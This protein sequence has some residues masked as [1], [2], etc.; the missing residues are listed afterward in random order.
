MK[1]LKQQKLPE[2]WQWKK[3]GE[4]AEVSSGNGAPQDESYFDNGGSPFVRTYDVGVFGRTSDLNESR[5]RINNQAVKDHGMQLFPARTLLIPKSGASTFLNNRALLGFP[6][7]VSSH[8]ATVIAKE[9]VL[10]EFL[11]Y[12]SLTVDAKRLTHDVSYPSLRLSEIENAEVPLPS[13]GTQ[14]KIISILQKAESMKQSRS[15]STKLTQ[16]LLQSV[17]LE[18]FGD[19][20]KNSMG[21]KISSIG[22]II[23]N[24][25]YGTSKK[26]NE[27][28][29]GYPCL[30]MNDINASG[31]IDDSEIKYVELELN[32]YKKYKLN[33][34][35][36]LFN[37]TNAPNLVGKTGIIRIDC[38]YVFA[39]YLI[40]IVPNKEMI[41]PEY[42]W[43][44][45]N[46]PTT[47]MKLTSMSKK[48]VNQANINAKELSRISLPIPPLESQKEFGDALIKIERINQID[49]TAYNEIE[50]I[51]GSINNM[52]F[53][54]ELVA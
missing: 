54:G 9:A 43:A 18:M 16:R 7:Y 27:M 15:Q 30:G 4:I 6:A 14:R 12:W 35:D 36:L 10:P 13:I 3:L 22:E 8:L 1:R 40:R 51:G 17:F 48:A 45:L 42:L 21:W 33:K 34:G 19:P 39:S 2:G 46:L 41:A 50:K 26:G 49:K 38:N 5:D 31:Y 29:K 23:K 37:R 47:K 20:V 32:D 52:A 53:K 11:Y 25:Q 44:Y 28:S 24:T